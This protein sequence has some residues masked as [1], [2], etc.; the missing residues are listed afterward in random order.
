[1]EATEVG[2]HRG[3]VYI[4]VKST[5]I[6]RYIYATYISTQYLSEANEVGQRR[7]HHIK[8]G[9]ETPDTK[10][11]TKRQKKKRKIKKNKTSAAT[12]SKV[13]SRHLTQKRKKMKN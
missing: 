3:H 9:V 1:L 4:P 8:R 5:D 11:K 12:T 7:G 13:G 10:K 6:Y 2:Q